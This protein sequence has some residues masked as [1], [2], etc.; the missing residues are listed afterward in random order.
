LPQHYKQDT[1]NV[2]TLF[3]YSINGILTNY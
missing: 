2:I 3:H 1:L